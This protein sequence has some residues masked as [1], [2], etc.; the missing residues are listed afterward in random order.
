MSDS[1]GGISGGVTAIAIK[2][3][4][5]VVDPDSC[6]FTVDRVVHPGGPFAY[7]SSDPVDDAPLVA[8]LFE[9]GQ[10]THVLIAG[11]TVTVSKS[12][13]ASWDTMRRGIG[14]AIREHLTAGSPV[15]LDR[16]ADDGAIGVSGRSERQIRVAIEDLLTG[17]VAPE[18]T[19][20]VDTTDHASGTAPFHPPGSSPLTSTSPIAITRSTNQRSHAP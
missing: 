3:E 18:I 8:R 15:I 14:A 11:P 4:T 5:S 6:K 2:A 7:R 1:A 17:M 10:I 13:A 9:L 19:A 20:I 12:S 16:V